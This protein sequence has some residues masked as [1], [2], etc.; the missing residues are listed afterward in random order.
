MVVF[1][2]DLLYT[3]LGKTAYRG[4]CNEHA[5]EELQVTLSDTFGEIKQHGFEVYCE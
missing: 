5:I 4:V 1:S 3:R 2:V